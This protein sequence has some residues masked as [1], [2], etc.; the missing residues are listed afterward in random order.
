MGKIIVIEPNTSD[1][2]QI[3]TYLVKGER[4]YSAYELYVQHGGTLTEEEWLNSFLNASNYYDKNEVDAITNKKPNYYNT[5]AEMKADITLADGDM[6]ITL[7]Y[8][9]IND[10]GGAT[11][12]IRTRTSTSESWDNAFVHYISGTLCAD[13]IIENSEVDIRQLG[14]RCLDKNNT[15][16]DIATYINK[17]LDYIQ[18]DFRKIKLHIP[19]GIW[20]CSPILFEEE[21]GFEI[22]GDARFTL[23][24]KEAGTTIT[25]LNNNQ[26]YIFKFGSSQNNCKSWTL[27][28]ICFSSSDFIYNTS[29]NTVARNGY[30][31]ITRAPW[32]L[33]RAM[34]GIS[35][36]IF[37]DWIEGCAFEL[38]SSWE[39][40]FGLLNFRHVNAMNSAI[41]TIENALTSSD[42]VTATSFEKIMCEA[43]LGDLFLVKQNANFGNSYIGTLNFEGWALTPTTDYV[44]TTITT[45]TQSDMDHHW[46][47]FNVFGRCEIEVNNI[48]LNNFAFRY[49]TYNEQDYCYDTL[50]N[51]SQDDA[52]PNMA[53]NNIALSGSK[54]DF[55]LLRQNGHYLFN[56]NSFFIGTVR[57][58][59]TTFGV[60]FDVQGARKIF[61]NTPVLNGNIAR[62]T[63]F[64][65]T[66]LADVIPFYEV[67]NNLVAIR[68][69]QTLQSAHY[70]TLYY[71]KNSRNNMHL[72]CKP[73]KASAGDGN[74]YIICAN[75]IVTGD[76]LLV[77][78]K[79]P[80]GSSVILFLMLD[81]ATRKNITLVGTGEYTDYTFTDINTTLPV[82]T[83]IAVRMSPASEEIDCYLDYYKFF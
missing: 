50:V 60:Y 79:V 22:V 72:V 57:F 35:D 68:Q 67:S 8:Y 73:Y 44:F 58:N 7:G 52:N 21:R 25:S 31:T 42:N 53:I 76:N 61:C 18:D 33:E 3:R 1:K 54:M 5:V 40:Y 62:E 82:G 2:D 56:L 32:V 48:E 24:H 6:A 41:I 37:F 66:K 23:D 38:G 55:P 39:N 65:I 45:E 78:A 16:E 12:K 83:P 15:K 63:D 51:V 34:Y 27:K 80:E 77:R 19:I 46:S 36:N 13:M 26:E 64:S 47:L 59:R 9:S 29:T 28:N 11:Y 69:D 17:Y 71:D 74:Y 75:L 30:K 14:A 70:G 20:F 43:T 49:L 4:G 81:S 10:G